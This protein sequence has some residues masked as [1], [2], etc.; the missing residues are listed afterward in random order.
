MPCDNPDDIF[1]GPDDQA[2]PNRARKKSCQRIGR[3]QALPGPYVRVPMQWILKPHRE[4]PFATRA[5]AEL[6]L[7]V[8]YRSHWGQRGVKLTDA[9]AAEVRVSGTTRKQVL[10][11]L[12]HKGWIRVERHPR[13]EAPVV[14][15]IVI[16]G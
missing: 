14:W 5:E 12:E 13:Q 15:P 10:R 1:L 2:S 6:F 16:A 8:L 9:V 4:S 3:L 7:L 11:R